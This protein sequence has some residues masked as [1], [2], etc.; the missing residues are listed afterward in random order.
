MR[1]SWFYCPDAVMRRAYAGG[2]LA[3]MAVVWLAYPL[4]RWLGWV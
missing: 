2:A 3:G 4:L 1:L